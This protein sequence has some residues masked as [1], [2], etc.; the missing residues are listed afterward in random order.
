MAVKKKS[1]N[2]IVVK[3]FVILFKR[4][5]LMV[6]FVFIIACLAF[7][8]ILINGILTN[9]DETAETQGANSGT[10][11]QTTLER[12]QSLH[13]SGNAGATPQVPAGRINPF[14]E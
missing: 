8:V 3:P 6:F 14:N 5:H 10:I 7:A 9:P 12:I 13:T 2:N 4:F 11:D 1:S